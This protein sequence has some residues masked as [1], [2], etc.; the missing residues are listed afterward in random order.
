M[1]WKPSWL[2]VPDFLRR[3]QKE[4]TDVG[5][6]PETIVET[7]PMFRKVDTKGGPALHVL[8][9]QG[10]VLYAVSLARDPAPV[11]RKRKDGN[12]LEHIGSIGQNTPFL[13]DID[14]T[15]VGLVERVDG[16]DEG[17]LKNFQSGSYRVTRMGEPGEINMSPFDY[18]AFL[19]DEAL[20]D[21]KL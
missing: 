1:V 8:N 6:Q 14:N 11:Y 3:G 16:A 18:L 2:R 20:K 19:R 10:V 9:E 21:P 13:T 17:A 12:F 7:R 15:G 4:R 5:S